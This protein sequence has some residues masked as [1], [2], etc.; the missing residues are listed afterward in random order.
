MRTLEVRRHTMRRKPGQRLSQDGIE[1]AR[2]VRDQS[3]HFDPVVSR[4]VPRAIETAIAMGYEVREIDPMLGQL[5]NDVFDAGVWPASFDKVERAVASE[6]PISRFADEQSRIW[7]GVAQKIPDGGKA[8]VVT[9]GLFVEA[10]AIAS[11]PE[12]DHGSWG[13][14]IGYCEGVRLTFDG[15]FEICQILHVP[16]GRHLVAN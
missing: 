5:P 2:L 8:L 3:G 10:G 16:D 9:H 14:A 12:A 7:T 15:T 1:L 11:L 4:V 6:G 13:G